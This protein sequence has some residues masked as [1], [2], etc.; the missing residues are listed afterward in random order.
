[1]AIDPIEKFKQWFAEAQASGIKEPDAMALA[2]A[3]VQGVPS[4]RMVL[5]RGMSGDGLRFFTNYESRKAD[6]LEANPRAALLL[7]WEP[8]GRQVRLEGKVE[9]LTAAESDDYFHHR[10]V[11][12][13]LNAL[14]SPQSRAIPDRAFL[15]HRYDRLVEQFA[16]KTVPRPPGWGGYR[17]LPQAIEFWTRGEDRLHERVLFRRS[18]N[19]WEQSL[20]AP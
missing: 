10:P 2:T 7:Y 18:E 5:F 6:E 20:L 8:L 16:E 1:M 19:G 9:R 13:Q 11:G 3:T 15:Q 17:L 12:H 14:A 4:V